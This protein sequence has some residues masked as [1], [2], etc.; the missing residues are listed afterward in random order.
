M[1]TIP[2]TGCAVF[3]LG[4]TPDER[5]GIV[6]YA[7]NSTAYPTTPRSDNI[8]LACRD[9]PFPSLVPVVPWAAKE[10]QRQGELG[11][12]VSVLSLNVL[13]TQRRNRG[14]V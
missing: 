3:E 11:P 2:A 13:L 1:R 12:S 6:Y 10:V 8:P 7:P 14:P 4:G 5:Q 9:E